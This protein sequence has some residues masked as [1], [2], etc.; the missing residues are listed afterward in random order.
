MAEED[1]VVFTLTQE[2]LDKVEHLLE[3]YAE[4][5]VGASLYGLKVD[6]PE[7]RHATAEKVKHIDEVMAA[8]TEFMFPE[9]HAVAQRAKNDFLT[10]INGWMGQN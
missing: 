9:R 8:V 2:Q 6:D 7:R 5:L 10:R 1:E 3:H 4:M